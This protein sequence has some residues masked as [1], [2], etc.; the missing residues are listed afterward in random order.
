MGSRLTKIKINPIIIYNSLLF[1]FSIV[2][3]DVM[4]FIRFGFIINSK[5]NENANMLIIPSHIRIIEIRSIVLGF[6]IPSGLRF[7]AT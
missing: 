1:L 7:L 5:L 6:K 3:S 4:E 2:N